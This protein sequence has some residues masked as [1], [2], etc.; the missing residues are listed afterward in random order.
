MIVIV[1]DHLD[2]CHA[3]LAILKRVR[4]PAECVDDPADA[5]RVIDEIGPRCSCSTR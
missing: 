5:I 4:I 1:D 2:T 3:L